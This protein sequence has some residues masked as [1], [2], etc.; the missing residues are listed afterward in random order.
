MAAMINISAGSSVRLYTFASCIQ[1]FPFEY[2]R[3]FLTVH[4]RSA[5]WLQC[6]RQHHHLLIRLF[7]Q[8]AGS[9]VSQA[10][11]NVVTAPSRN[12]CKY[13]TSTQEKREQCLLLNN[14]DKHYRIF[15]AHVSDCLADCPSAQVLETYLHF[16]SSFITIFSFPLS[17][18]KI[19]MLP[20]LPGTDLR[21]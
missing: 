17:S 20:S 6:G 11:L 4:F 13:S 5:T 9:D 19:F 7:P 10:A 18:S 2:E 16:P 14:A 15:R 3:V 8:D 12:V 21:Q 1:P